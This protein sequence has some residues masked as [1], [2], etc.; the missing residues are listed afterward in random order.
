MS[1]EQAPQSEQLTR[2]EIADQIWGNVVS[3][4][5]QEQVDASETP[6]QPR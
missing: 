1:N 4:I 5:V 6:D 3:A 2:A